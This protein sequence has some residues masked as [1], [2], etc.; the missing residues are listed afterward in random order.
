MSAALPLY[1][2]ILRSVSRSFYLSIRLLPGGVR[3]PS[4]LAYLLAR[5]SDTLADT[6]NVT[7]PL[8]AETLATLA[9]VIQ[10]KNSP[11]A[12]ADLIDLFAPHQTNRA[13]KRLIETLPQCIE[14]LHRLEPADQG[15]VRTVLS[16]IN[17][18][19]TLDL[20]RFGDRLE[21]RA[22]ATDLELH[23]YTYLVAGS[24]GEF[25]TRLCLRHLRNF[26]E[27]SEAEM[28]E[29]ARGYGSGLQLIN[30]LRDAHGDLQAG[31]CYFPMEDLKE[32]GLAPGDILMDPGRFE[33]VFEKWRNEAQRGLTA[34]MN[35]V[36]GIRSRRVRAAT[37][38]PALI[39]ARTL[40]LLRAA[41]SGALRLNIKVPR[42]EV[43]AMIWRV[44]TALASPNVLNRMFVDA[45]E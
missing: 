22:L 23:E 39:G 18:G 19:Q 34:G 28:L 3:R 20:L 36:H 15:D 9:A 7:P 2:S 26:S 31:R 42:P 40:S 27:R 13:E 35:Y 14:E 8:R 30:I 1:R 25:W 29:L 43:R 37:V 5:A 32:I 45:L 17:Q 21:P 38:L 44:A 33:F 24:V 4:G 11:D 16:K 6:T 10:D 41:G 12:L